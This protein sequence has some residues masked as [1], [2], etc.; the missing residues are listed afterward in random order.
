MSPGRPP[1]SS[2]RILWFSLAIVALTLLLIA[3]LSTSDQNNQGK[4]STSSI[5]AQQVLPARASGQGPA[6]KGAK[7]KDPAAP[8]PAPPD[9]LYHPPII[10]GQVSIA[11]QDEE[12]RASGYSQD[13][14]DK[15][16]GLLRVP[17]PESIRAGEEAKELRRQESRDRQAARKDGEDVGPRDT[18]AS[19][20]GKVVDEHQQVLDDSKP[21]QERP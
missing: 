12:Y 2:S 18:Q 11:G 7:L 14:I 4:Q 17:D 3:R 5:P 8:A 16:S 20:P 1:P 10:E 6:P 21:P 19:G 13:E 9:R 15:L